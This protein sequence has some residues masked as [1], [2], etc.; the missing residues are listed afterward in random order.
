MTRKEFKGMDFQILRATE[1]SMKTQ[2]NRGRLVGYHQTW[3]SL[4]SMLMEQSEESSAVVVC[5][6]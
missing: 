1:A 5:E 4:N 6:F 2:E 3:A